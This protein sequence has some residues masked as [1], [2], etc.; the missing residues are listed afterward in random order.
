MFMDIKQII[1]QNRLCD[2][3]MFLA[4]ERLYNDVMKM[5]ML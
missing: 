3:F 1:S 2:A 4:D 5:S